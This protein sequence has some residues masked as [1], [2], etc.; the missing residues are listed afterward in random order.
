MFTIFTE[1]FKERKK[2]KRT[3]N[4]FTTLDSKRGID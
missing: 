3:K 1:D 4:V 2:Y